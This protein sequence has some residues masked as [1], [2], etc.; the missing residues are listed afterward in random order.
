MLD[1]TV[2]FRSAFARQL[3]RRWRAVAIASLK[4]ILRR[5][6]HSDFA[7]NRG[8]AL[9]SRLDAAGDQSTPAALEEFNVSDLRIVHGGRENTHTP[10]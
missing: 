6:L 1:V 3:I 2:V 7:A 10:T 8:S 9:G 4:P 5:S